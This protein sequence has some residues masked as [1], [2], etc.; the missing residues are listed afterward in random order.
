MYIPKNKDHACDLV[1]FSSPSVWHM[2]GT[3]RNELNTRHLRGPMLRGCE[4]GW[5]EAG[6][7]IK[8]QH[9]IPTKGCAF[10]IPDTSNNKM[11]GHLSRKENLANR[12]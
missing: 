5:V 9:G 7:C 8:A 6:W 2:A 3:L 11:V 4:S 10:V 1:H 12:K